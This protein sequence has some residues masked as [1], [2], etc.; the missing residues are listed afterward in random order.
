MC[1]CNYILYGARL[2]QQY[3]VNSYCKIET[4]QQKYL[5]WEQKNLWAD[6]C[7]DLH[8]ML[9]TE[10]GDPNDVVQVCCFPSNVH[11]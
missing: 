6:N 3:L 7:G 4:E 9:L 2:F 10:N 1:E 11:W 5:E 8:N